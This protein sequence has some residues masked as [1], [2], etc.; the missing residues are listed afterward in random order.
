MEDKDY[1]ELAREQVG[2]LFEI[3]PNERR[4]I[5]DF[6]EKF[7]EDLKTKIEKTIKP[8]ALDLASH[9]FAVVYKN[10]RLWLCLGGKN[11]LEIEFSFGD[12][13]P[14]LFFEF[15]DVVDTIKFNK[16]KNDLIFSNIGKAILSLEVLRDEIK[17]YEEDKKNDDSKNLP[18]SSL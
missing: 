4:K 7:T 9:A 17:K 12:D 13:S 5:D 15:D 11:G 1:D 6:I 2:D 10:A 16:A 3:N 8:S 18:L 14:S